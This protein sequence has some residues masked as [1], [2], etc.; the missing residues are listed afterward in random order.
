[1]ENGASNRH[2][3]GIVNV[4][5][6]W[7]AIRRERDKMPTQISD[8]VQH[9]RRAILRQDQAGLTDGQLL[10]QFIEH[11]DEAAVAALVRR[12]GPM[13]W[14]VCRRILLNHHEAE[15]AFQA[16][17]LVLVR[18][19]TSITQREKVGNWL[20]GVARQ[21]AMK[22]RAMLAKRRTRESQVTTMPD[23]QGPEQDGWCD[24]QPVLDQEL[25]RLPEKYRVAIVLCDLEGKTRK[26]AAR[27]LGLPEGTVA[28][29]LTRGRAMLAKRLTRHGLALSG[30][31]LACVL[32]Q[33]AA[34]ASVPASVTSSAIKA[35]TSVAAGQAVAGVVSGP[36][37]ALRKEC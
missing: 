20:Y 37:A 30:P 17:F 21:T 35:V 32:T 36:V 12:H 23:V 15:E 8:V 6:V 2:H 28:G 19:A 18:R 1:M 29:R 24:L 14:G 4:E 11:R 13:V 33:Q 27:Q 25:S 31:A 34:S 26:G 10:G 3:A 9:L 16:T 5:R 22:A 7:V